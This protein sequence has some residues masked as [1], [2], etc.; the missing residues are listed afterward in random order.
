MGDDSRRLRTIRDA[1]YARITIAY[2][3]AARH[4]RSA[5][6]FVFDKR[7]EIHVIARNIT[8]ARSAF[9]TR[10]QRYA[11]INRDIYSARE[12]YAEIIEPQMIRGGI[13]ANNQPSRARSVIFGPRSAEGRGRNSVIIFRKH[14]RAR[15]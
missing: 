3:G 8:H 6:R 2:Y 15:A 4:N 10:H 9:A 12:G 7:R 11:R 14:L 1:N 5:A 13:I